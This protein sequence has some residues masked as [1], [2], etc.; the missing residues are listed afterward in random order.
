[1]SPREIYYLKRFEALQEIE[2]LSEKRV[3]AQI[4]LKTVIYSSP[5]LFFAGC[6]FMYGIMNL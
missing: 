1:M 2:S 4:D 6:F 3:K 5:L